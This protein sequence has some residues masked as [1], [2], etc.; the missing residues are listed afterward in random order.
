LPLSLRDTL[1]GHGVIVKEKDENA[2]KFASESEGE[3]IEFVFNKVKPLKKQD[4]K[5]EDKPKML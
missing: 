3:G 2:Q 4:E 1:K 5:E